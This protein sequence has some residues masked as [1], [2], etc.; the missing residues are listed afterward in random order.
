TWELPWFHPPIEWVANTKIGFDGVHPELDNDSEFQAWIAENTGRRHKFFDDSDGY[1]QAPWRLPGGHPDLVDY[2]EYEDE[3]VNQ[4]IELFFD[5]PNLQDAFLEGGTMPYEHPSA[6]YLMRKLLPDVHPSIDDLFENSTRVLPEWHI[7]LTDLLYVSTMERVSVPYGHPNPHEMYLTLEV[8]PQSHPMITSLLLPY[9][10]PDHPENLDDMLRNPADFPMPNF[11]P[12]LARFLLPERTSDGEV[13]QETKPTESS[14]VEVVHDSEPSSTNDDKISSETDSSHD[15]EST[16]DYDSLFVSNLEE[17][18]YVPTFSVF[19]GH[20]DLTSEYDMG[21]PVDNH[22]SVY[23]M[24]EDYLPEG[25]PNI[26]I[27]MARGFVL[28]SYHPDIRHVVEQRSLVSSPGSLL[29]YAVASLVVLIVL[30]QNIH[31]LKRRTEEIPPPPKVMGVDQSFQNTLVTNEFEHEND[32]QLVISD[33]SNDNDSVEVEH[34]FDGEL[35]HLDQR[36]H[37]AMELNHNHHDDNLGPQENVRGSILAYKEKKTT[38]VR[39]KWNK[40]FGQRVIK[41]DLSM[42]EVVN[43]TLYVLINLAALLASPTYGYSIGLGSLSAGNT[44][45]LVMTATRNSVFTWLIGLTFD[46]ALI[47]HRFIGRLTVV[48]SIIHSALHYEHILD[49]TSERITVTGL[50]AL[51]CGIVIFATSLN[52]VRRKL[53]NV[54]FWSHFAFVGFIVGMY[55]HAAG[56]RPFI[57]ASVACYGVDKLL[58]LVWTQLPRRTTK[59]EKVG[60]RTAHVQF[61]KTP[62]NVL[63]GRY[64]VG[65]YIFVNFP[66]LSLTEWHPFSVA[67]GPSEGCVDLYIRALG[68][69]TKKIVDYAE[70]CGAEDKQTLIRCDGPYGDLSFNYRRFGNL[71]LVGGGIGITP[72]ISVLKDIYGEQ[73][74]QNGNKPRHCVRNVTL[75]W[76]MPRA[77][78]A[79]L[80][81]EMLNQFR[82]KSLEDTL[83]PE[84][85]LAVYITRDDEK[86]HDDQILYGK[87]DFEEVVSQCVDEMSSFTRSMLVYACGPGSMVNQLWDVSI[88]KPMKKDGKRI[89]VD[90][91]HESFEF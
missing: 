82:L 58:A 50:V 16:D 1:V 74:T 15:S 54:F 36:R 27:L 64:K 55:L 83:L 45:F 43:C 85:N 40:A 34:T 86:N 61:K 11:H 57:W 69:H 70:A 7:D 76:I 35:P 38:M 51:S 71:L 66:E 9:L 3:P 24:F 6:D 62:L 49:K 21:D 65:Q 28:P 31:K 30:V 72:I 89:R 77:S 87:P 8:P 13:V 53:F 84:F 63:L 2:F 19:F 23:Y 46:Q 59:F 33:S 10:P 26:D 39:S 44:F 20:P 75:V 25:H 52:Y 81:L 56:A 80:F 67:S 14:G 37:H 41:S 47:Y 88:K 90:F 42:G 79:S 73:S 68:N 17:A 91:Y 29:S 22:P 18:Y 60:E 4:Y 32:D 12:S 78:E 48:I 5:H